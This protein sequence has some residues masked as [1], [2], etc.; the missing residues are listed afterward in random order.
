MINDNS[1]QEV[2]DQQLTA[3]KDK[4]SDWIWHGFVAKGNMTLVTGMWKGAGKT[5]LLSLLLS[6]RKEG[7]NLAGLPVRPGKTV[8]VTE[9]STALW[10]DRARQ[11]DFGGQACFF[12]RP[13]LT[14]PTPEQW[15]GLMR[16]ILN[17]RQAH[18]IDLAVIDP[19]APFLPCENNARNMFDAILPLTALI[20][21][22]M[23]VVA[24]HHP[25]KGPKPAG[26]AARGSGALLGHVDISIEIRSPGGD[27]LTRRR[28]L[29]AL[30]R[31]PE[32]P[33]Q[34]LVELDAAGS[35]Y[36]VLADDEYEDQFQA[37]WGVLR[38]VLNQAR[39]KL[40]R[41]EILDEWPPDFDNKPHLVTLG[42]WLGRA[43]E[44]G[45]IAS[46]GAGLKND[47]FRFW[48]PEREAVWR[49]DPLYVLMEEGD[50]ERTEILKTLEPSWEFPKATG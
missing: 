40:T 4:A 49:Q 14:I 20:R 38:M 43:V 25:A 23:A 32:T 24:M 11:L 6:R 31:Y 39:K 16:K 42:R 3:I 1:P 22:G 18:G 10:G 9:E 41:L 13:F 17:L 37:N 19:L 21:A 8:I 47:P 44:R 27:P 45:L 28:R 46:D 33:R 29:L 35:D 7:G 26:E 50:R 15:H 34:L 12:S 36:L 5:A 2:W 30:S 48:L